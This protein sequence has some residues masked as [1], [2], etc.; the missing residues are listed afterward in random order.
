MYSIN[1]CTLILVSVCGYDVYLE[2]KKKKLLS[3]LNGFCHNCGRRGK[4]SR[5]K[6]RKML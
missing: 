2:W 1:I 6:K 5:V 4:V 3:N